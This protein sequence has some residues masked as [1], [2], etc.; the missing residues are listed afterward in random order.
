MR[1]INIRLV[2]LMTFLCYLIPNSILQGQNS[3]IAVLDFDGFG[4]SS[5]EAI[6]LSNR[7]RN[8]FFR[9]GNFEVVDRGLMTNILSE[10][11]F[12][13]SGCTSNECL[14]EVGR[15]L[16]AQY[17]VGGSVSRFGEMF[18]VSARLVD[19]QTGRVLKVSDFDQRGRFEDL[20]TTGMAEV[21]GIL[22][23]PDMRSNASKIVWP[24]ETAT[25]LSS[26]VR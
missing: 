18:T 15:L 3:P 14:V 17:M 16:G 20:L 26:T 8:E 12:Q 6:T 19:V 10:Q 9:Q 23:M 1:P 2:I 11:D 7:L 4:I 25:S 21:A 13:Q 22:P 5:E 24:P